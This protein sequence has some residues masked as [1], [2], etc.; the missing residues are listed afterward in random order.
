MS[1]WPPAASI[2]G[3]SPQ[4]VGVARAP[5]GGSSGTPRASSAQL[6]NMG[7]NT[8][9]YGQKREFNLKDFY[10]T[11]PVM[12]RVSVCMNLSQTQWTT[13]CDKPGRWKSRNSKLP[14]LSVNP[15]SNQH[16][17]TDFF[18][19]SCGSSESEVVSFSSWLC[20]PDITASWL[21][22]SFTVSTTCFRPFAFG[23]LCRQFVDPLFFRTI[24]FLNEL[25]VHPKNRSMVWCTRLCV[26]V[27]VYCSWILF[28]TT[29]ISAQ[30]ASQHI[31]R[32][33]KNVRCDVHKTMC[34]GFSLLFMNF[35]LYA[36][37]HIKQ[38]PQRT[39]R[40]DIQSSRSMAHRFILAPR[41]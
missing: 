38:G 37:Q 18:L 2:P 13:C 33:Q 22:N 40:C 41:I 3:A 17:S 27:S 14:M 10:S 19:T 24:W 26:L 6:C 30:Y 9:I 35:V 16:S 23:Q 5:R 15:W 31:T 34:F 25:Q 8:H 21:F 11:C 4:G 12:I 29:L 39:I 28:K 1:S 36:S 7:V 32:T 20:L